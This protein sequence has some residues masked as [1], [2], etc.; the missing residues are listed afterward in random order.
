MNELDIAT[1][2]KKSY[3][4][5]VAL[6]SRTFLLQLLAFAATFLLTIF[7]S[8]SVF[9]V[10]YVVSAIISFLGYFSDIGLAAA[11]IQKKEELTGDDLTTTFTIQQLLV[12]ILTIIALA[13]SPAVASYYRLDTDG[14]WLFCALVISFFL[15]SLKTI[16][17]VLLERK[18]NFQKLVIPQIAETVGFY[19]VAVVLAWRGFGVASFTWAVLT[20]G[21]IG[22][23]VMYILAPWH[24]GLGISRIVAKRLIKFGLPFQT[25]SLLALVKDDLLTVFLGRVLPFAEVGYIG[26]AKKWAEVPLRLIMDSVM[27]VTFPAFSRIQEAKEVLGRAIERTL[28]G[29]SLLVFPISVGLLFFI[30]PLIDAVPRYEKWEPALFSFYLFTIGAAVSSLSTPLTNALNAIGKIKTTLL[31][32]IMWTTTTW[33]LTVLFV[34]LFGFNGVA[35]AL[36]IITSS[37]WIVI[38]VM[39]QYAAFSFWKSV[40]TALLGV[41]I[42]GF[43]YWTL[44]SVSPGG[45][46]WYGGVGLLGV[47]LYGAVVWTLE[48]H[49]I[50]T[51]YSDLR[52]A[53]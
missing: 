40:R 45:A 13:A 18:L 38:H 29:L 51:I 23:V 53:L 1:I 16:P 3:S 43:V 5:I 31:L 14:L 19:V 9:G 44:L 39:K 49:R 41:L 28:F 15:S 36:L 42:Q 46:L 34:R 6:T 26:W 27:R 52:K 48:R 32:M 47:I 7:L 24:I 33:V 2:K 8:P 17:S 22:L 4:G 35:L 20:R 50:Q 11:L 25:N 10:F 30:R 21:I 12:G 37:L